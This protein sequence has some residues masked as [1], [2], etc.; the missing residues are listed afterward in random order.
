MNTLYPLVNNWVYHEVD[1]WHP[2]K[3]GQPADQEAAHDESYVQ[4][5]WKKQNICNIYVQWLLFVIFRP[6]RKMQN[7]GRLVNKKSV[8]RQF[9][10]KR[11][12][13]PWTFF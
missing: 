8:V 2:D 13:G 4:G 5:A 1:Q 3:E 12:T 10:Y 7:I 11:S 9:V 6:F